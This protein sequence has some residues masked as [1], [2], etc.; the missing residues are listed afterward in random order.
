MGYFE[1]SG[2]PIQAFSRGL[3]RMNANLKRSIRINNAWK[4]RVEKD[5]EE[6][7]GVGNLFGLVFFRF[8]FIRVNPRLNFK[9]TALDAKHF[10][11][12]WKGSGAACSISPGRT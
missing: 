5:S 10:Q 6:L 8:A 7:V 1:Y 2:H 12:R 11:K 3:T 4:Q 9:L